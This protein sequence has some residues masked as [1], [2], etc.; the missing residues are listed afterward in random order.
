MAAAE[1]LAQSPKNPLASVV[2][3]D[4]KWLPEVTQTLVDAIVSSHPSP[5][6]MLAKLAV[7]V[8]KWPT[9][10]YEV[11]DIRYAWKA[12]KTVLLAAGIEHPTLANTRSI[13]VERVREL[14]E[15][16]P[17]DWPTD[18]ISQVADDLEHLVYELD[19]HLRVNY[20]LWL[21]AA[22]EAR[23]RDETSEED[24]VNLADSYSDRGAGR[25]TVDIAGLF[26]DMICQLTEDSAS[27]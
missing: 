24:G 27:S 25:G 14:I 20:Q 2:R 26:E 10:A 8:T 17:H 23:Q 5:S 1:L 4:L 18:E 15:E 22:D 6:S 12:A 11:S 21:E 7:V 9:V 13:F 3:D 19:D 16:V